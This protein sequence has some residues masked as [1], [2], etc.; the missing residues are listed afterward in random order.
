MYKLT[1]NLSNFRFNSFHQQGPLR[2]SLYKLVENE[3]GS[4]LTHD[5]LTKLTNYIT[6]N[7][8]NFSNQ[9][10]HSCDTDDIPSLSIYNSIPSGGFIPR[11]LIIRKKPQMPPS[12]GE[13][14]AAMDIELLDHNGTTNHSYNLEFD[15]IGE[16]EI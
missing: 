6:G 9:N 16:V 10:Y 5:E 12:G 13:I 8:S 11:Y 4:G 7:K 1:V 15:L 3:D 14:Y 2:I